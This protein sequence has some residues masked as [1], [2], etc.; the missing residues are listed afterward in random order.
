M[1]E[2]QKRG[3][4]HV[5]IAVKLTEEP[6]AAEEIN[7]IVRATLRVHDAEPFEGDQGAHDS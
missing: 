6:K 3:L 1:T 7:R 4:P 2:F 5:H